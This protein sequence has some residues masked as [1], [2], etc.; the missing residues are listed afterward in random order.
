MLGWRGWGPFLLCLADPLQAP[1]ELGS[2]LGMLPPLVSVFVLTP[3][4]SLPGAEVTV[5]SNV[6][7]GGGLGCLPFIQISEDRC[8]FLQKS[9][10]P[11]QQ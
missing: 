2:G 10:L 3:F 9:E 7:P 8:S 1:D 6:G 4:L 11:G 5:W